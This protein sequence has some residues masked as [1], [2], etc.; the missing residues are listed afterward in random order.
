MNKTFAAIG[1]Q[2]FKTY[3]LKY[4]LPI[5]I[6]DFLLLFLFLFGFEGTYLKWLG[7]IFFFVVLLVVF[8]YPSMIIDNQSRDIEENLHY[9]ITY[10]GALSTV[11][12]ER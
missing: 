9:F 10:A 12:L 5:F 11:N 8:M 1:V 4:F 2:D 7:I 6:G 3:L